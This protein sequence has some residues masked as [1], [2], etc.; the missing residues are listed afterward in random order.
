MTENSFVQGARVEVRDEEWMVLDS[1]GTD[2]DGAKLKVVGVS[3]LV[4]GVEATFFTELDDVE[5]IRPEDTELVTEGSSRYAQSR[6]FLEAVLRRTPL[7][8]TERGLAMS[9]SFLL[10]P[11][12]YQQRPA[13]Q[14]LAGLRPRIL[15]A[16]VVGLGKTL[17]IGLTLAELIR[18]GRGERIL[19]V[20]PQHVLEQFQR[21]MWTRFSI[22]LLRMD[23]VG[24]SRIQQQLPAGRNPFTVHKRVIIS[25]DTLKNE[26][27]YR[28]HLENLQWDVVVL[29]ESHNLVGGQK[30]SQRRILAE[31]LAKKTDALLLASATPH[32]G[33]AESFAGLID[34][35]D[36]TAIADKKHYSAADINDL[37][38]RRTKVDD[39]VRGEIYGRWADRG[40]P[41]L[42]DVDPSAAEEAVFAEFARTWDPRTCTV[43]GPER[44]LFPF[45]LIKAFLSS[46]AA[47]AET[48]KNRLKAATGTEAEALRRLAGLNDAITAP[49]KLHA[50]ASR[51]KEIG[52]G[53]KSP[54]RVVVFSER[55]DTVKWLAA[56]IPAITGLKP[57]QIEVL[58]GGLSDTEQ[59]KVVEQ[60]QLGS[61]KLRVL[62]TGD[63]ASEGVNFHQHCH[64]LVHWDVP[65][66]MIRI[67]QRNGRIDRYG[68]MHEP[69]FTA[70]L[71]KSGAFADFDD[72]RVS[73]KLVRKAAT[74]AAALGSV[75][76]AALDV[77]SAVESRRI[78]EGLIA[79]RG[80]D[81]TVPDVTEPD[82]G[83]LLS[84]ING[85]AAARGAA[86]QSPPLT[87][88]QPRLFAGTQEFVETA[89]A[90]LG[91]EADWEGETL[92]ITP[93]EDLKQRLQVLPPAYLKEHKVTE[94]LWVTCDR[95][96]A[97][98]RLDKAVDDTDMAWP[99]TAFLSDLHPLVEWLVDKAL[100][101]LGR[102]KAP[103]IRCDVPEP[104]F[105]IQGVYTNK[106]GQPA[107]VEWM[108]VTGFDTEPA[109]SG[110]LIERLHTAGVGPHMANSNQ[111][112]DRAPLQALVKPAITAARAFLEGRRAEADAAIAAEI[113][114]HQEHLGDWQQA[115][116]ENFDDLLPNAGRRRSTVT[117]TAA[118]QRRHI[119]KLATDGL[120]LLRVLAVLVPQG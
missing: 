14:A 48:V 63:I 59:Q 112:L 74:A 97:Q 89:L 94:R 114:K 92:M 45:T 3:D 70:L 81:E 108:T 88:T 80:I 69:Q 40:E 96:H 64:Q 110:D 52:I 50:L 29:D 11:M 19:V 120:P 77:D 62:V 76:A 84:M 37:Y 104:V 83:D 28:H 23:S 113:A 119:E 20:T 56:Q 31:L 87:A 6:L 2:H 15:I 100:V 16:D 98:K 44:R 34:L 5:L 101:K 86:Q 41:R 99:D 22:P 13:E 72:T 91:I 118:D 95:D 116:L 21:E 1:R 53:P 43:I 10:N 67:E 105:G 111:P 55:I 25:I 39:E 38:I 57:N 79:G 73:G 65:W 51:L 117:D 33:N 109:V 54:E 18:R 32:N 103:I 115:A 35:L 66:S 78:L 47:L 12:T 82:P 24:I 90:D 30:K 93:P 4:R 102:G 42:V 58:H 26:S 7:A 9:E 60:F 17:E 107:V 106:A 68:Q 71:L 27:A 8:R 49:A 61:S 85:P 36:P 75:E 46:P